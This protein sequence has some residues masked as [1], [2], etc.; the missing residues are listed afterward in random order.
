MSRKVRNLS[1]VIKKFIFSQLLAFLTRCSLL[2]LEPKTWRLLRR[3]QCIFLSFPFFQ[4]PAAWVVLPSSNDDA[5][6]ILQPTWYYD[7]KI[8]VY[9]VWRPFERHSYSTK[10][11][12]QQKNT[13]NLTP[14]LSA[15]LCY[16]CKAV[17]WASPLSTAGNYAW[18]NSTCNHPPPG[19]PPG[20]CNFVLT[21]RTIPHPRA[22]KKRQF[23]T[24]GTAH[25]PQIRCF[26]YKT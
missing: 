17:S 16:C 6:G 22:R 25:R 11:A 23:P 13:Q 19:I 2:D 8:S 10:V 21:W 7:F 1:P 12:F 9:C 26:V 24:P 4:V 14:F 18:F 20:I 3:F 5:F 15:C